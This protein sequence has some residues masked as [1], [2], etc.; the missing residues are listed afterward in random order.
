[1]LRQLT[2][3]DF[4]LVSELELDFH[5]GFTV[6]TGETGAGKSIL[7]D[8]LQLAMG[9]RGDAAVVREGQSRAEVCASFEIQSQPGLARWLDEAGFEHGHEE[10]LLRRVIDLQG[11]SRAWINGSPATMT[12][13]RE[14][15]AFLIDIHGQHAWQ[16][17]MKADRV[18]SLLDAYG[19]ID[20]SPLQAVWRTW[21]EAQQRLDAAQ[22]HAAGAQQEHERL[23]WQISE[24]EKLSPQEGE[25]DTLSAEHERL[26]HAHMLIESAQMAS[27]TVNGEDHGITQQLAQVAA[28]LE[29]AASIDPHLAD[30]L[31]VLHDANALLEDAGHS[32]NSWLRHTDLDPERLEVLDARMGSWVS[33]ARRYR[34]PPQELAQLLEKWKQELMALEAGADIETLQA[35]AAHAK[36]AFLDVAASISAKRRQAASAL[37]LSITKAMQGLGMTGG[38]FDVEVSPLAEPQSSGIDRIEFLVAG[39]AGATPRPVGKVASGGEL[40]RL[41]LAISVTTSQLGHT[42]TLIFD[43]VDSG[44]GGSVAQTVG[45]LMRQ[46]GLDRQVLAVTHLPQVAAYAHQHLVVSKQGASKDGVAMSQVLPVEGEGR[47]KEI[48]R[49]LGGDAKSKAGL[50]HAREMLGAVDD[51]MH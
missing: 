2:L 21:Q 27:H 13:L 33:L 39:H 35:H 11:K 7:I 26:S 24:L 9:G 43:E 46:L 28:A 51:A 45:E 49:M 32:L 37:A 15:G 25:W 50:A 22:R 4:V 19:R 12:Q 14:A 34:C 8:A 3:R 44:I 17:L 20:V 47:V 1:M 41:A 48:A 18:R 16:S 6:L 29:K 42:P 5:A 23:T 10:L 38:R 40:S 31:K 30:I 36:K